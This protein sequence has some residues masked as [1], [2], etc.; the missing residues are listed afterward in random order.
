MRHFVSF[1][2]DT[3]LY[4]KLMV[5]TNLLRQEVQDI[6]VT[7]YDQKWDKIYTEPEAS[8]I[9]QDVYDCKDNWVMY[10]VEVTQESK[11]H[12]VTLEPILAWFKKSIPHIS[13]KDKA[14]QFNK[15]NSIVI[16]EDNIIELIYELIGLG[17]MYNIN[18]NKDLTKLNQTK[19]SSV[20]ET[21]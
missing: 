3:N 10:G 7:E 18:V 16:N 17:Y 20:N 6:L 9:L 5:F 2:P 1:K 19:W 11:E 14:T 15:V 12:A 8:R 21:K 13:E 4:G